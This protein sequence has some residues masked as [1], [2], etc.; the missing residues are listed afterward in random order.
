MFRF[1]VK[2][3]IHYEN[4]RIWQYNKVMTVQLLSGNQ[5][6]KMDLKSSN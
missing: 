1:Y 2:S 3:N 6:L 4:N 5:V